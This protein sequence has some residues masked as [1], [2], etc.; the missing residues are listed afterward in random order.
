ML[1]W[2]CVPTCEQQKR[3]CPTEQPSLILTWLLFSAHCLFPLC[4]SDRD[5]GVPNTCHLVEGLAA[6]HQHAHR[7]G[8]LQALLQLLQLQI[9]GT[10]TLIL[11][12]R[13][14]RRF[15]AAV[16]ESARKHSLPQIPGPWQLTGVWGGR[17]S[18]LAAWEEMGRMLSWSSMTR[19]FLHEARERINL[20]NK[21]TVVRC[22][23]Q[24]Q[25]DKEGLFFRKIIQPTS[26]HHRL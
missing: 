7:L 23:E 26:L 19:H 14:R 3:P 16:G 5:G 6:V 4:A 12:E 10:E 8:V 17:A 22:W 18:M 25:H 11:P 21:T 9:R 15:T 2:C 20:R 13:R 1:C 24:C